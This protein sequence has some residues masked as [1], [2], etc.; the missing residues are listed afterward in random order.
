MKKYFCGSE[1][2]NLEDGWLKTGDMAILY[3]DGGIE[4]LGRK[5]NLFRPKQVEDEKDNETVPKIIVPEK[6]EN[7]LI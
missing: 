3:P 2:S 7:V 5:E 6:I 4:I 1:S